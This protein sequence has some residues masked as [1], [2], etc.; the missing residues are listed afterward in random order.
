MGVSRGD[1]ALLTSRFEVFNRAVHPDWYSTREFSRVEQLGWEA[2]IRILDGAMRLFSAG[3]TIRLTEILLGPETR[4]P[5]PVNCF[6]R[7]FA[8]KNP[9]FSDGR[10]DRVP[11]LPRGRTG[12]Y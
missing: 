11:V 3:G 9:R 5:R 8:A 6:I 10:Q 12:R 7:T 1:R 2:D 4:F